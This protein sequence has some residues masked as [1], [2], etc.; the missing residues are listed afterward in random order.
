MNSRYQ[1]YLLTGLLALLA[2]I[3]IFYLTGASPLAIA[4]GGDEKFAALDVK[5][6]AL[7]LDRL[8]RIHK[9]AYPG[10]RRNIFSG[11]PPPPPPSP[12]PPPMPQPQ[13][14]P[15]VVVP[16]LQVPFK[17]YGLTVDPRSGKRRAFFTNGEDVFIVAEGETL[18]ARY[19]LLRIGN[20]T[21]DFEELGTGLRATLPLELPAQPPQG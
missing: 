12:T 15:P 4:L 14:P 6:P 20:T 1:V 18:L 13:P 7:R 9:L 5:D 8:E 2:G 10:M 3:V 17:F 16:V 11:E 19:R 21:A